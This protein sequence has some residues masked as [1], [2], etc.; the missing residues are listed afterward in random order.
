VTCPPL[1]GRR[2]HD[3]PI[4][5]VSW[6]VH[7]R[8]MLSGDDDGFV[9]LWDFEPDSSAAAS[10]T[11]GDALVGVWDTKNGTAQPVAVNTWRAHT[12]PVTRVLFLARV[13]PGRPGYVRRRCRCLVLRVAV[14][15]PCRT[16]SFSFLLSPPSRVPCC[17]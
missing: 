15:V 5:A 13:D 4:R 2:A 8:Y 3:D 16:M 12:F 10:P 17:A 9:S 14:T 11:R 7:G 1:P 6:H